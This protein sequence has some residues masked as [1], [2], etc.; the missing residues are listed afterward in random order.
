[1]E[2]YGGETLSQFYSWENWG[3]ER[4]S[5]VP[6]FKSDCVL[7]LSVSFYTYSSMTLPVLYILEKA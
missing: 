2:K 6:N 7:F 4:L 5:N 1:M 3:V